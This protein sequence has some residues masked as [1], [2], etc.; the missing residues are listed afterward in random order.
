MARGGVVKCHKSQ[1]TYI[2]WF[3]VYAEGN[4]VLL[5]AKIG[6]A[7]VACFTYHASCCPFNMRI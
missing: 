6:V 4:S 1:P 2:K 5:S 3:K 7:R